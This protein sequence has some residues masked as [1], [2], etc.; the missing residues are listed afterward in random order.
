MNND[1][2]KQLR[3]INGYTQSQIASFLNMDQSM[4][5]RIEAGTRNISVTDLEK[6]LCLYGVEYSKYVQNQTSK[7]IK[8]AYRAKERSKE[9]LDHIMMI[10]KIA[11]NLRFMEEL[12]RK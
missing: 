12:R 3:E 2:L 9:D 5:N 6:L 10:K 8:M 11:L 7:N 1:S 4:V